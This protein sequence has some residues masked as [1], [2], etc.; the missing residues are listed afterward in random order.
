M[1][2]FGLMELDPAGFVMRYSPAAVALSVPL[3]QDVVGR[4]FFNELMPHAEVKEFKYRFLTFMAEGDSI[5]R[6]ST[7][8]AFENHTVKVQVMLARLTERSEIRAERLALVRIMPDD[9]AHT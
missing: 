1:V 5:Q 4:N 3:A 7:S 9:L 2:P 8:F 6:F